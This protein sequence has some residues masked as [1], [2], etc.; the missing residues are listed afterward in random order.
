MWCNV[1]VMIVIKDTTPGLVWLKAAKEVV[2]NGGS[3]MD[4]ETKLKELLNVFLTVEKPTKSDKILEQFADKEM[5]SWM[6]N[7]FL[8]KEPVANWGYSYG[9]RFFDF[10]GINQVEAVIAKLK[11]NHDSKSATI[12]LMSPKGDTQHMPC[13]VA[14]DFKLRGGKLYTTAFFRSQ[15]AGKKLYA[16][17]ISIGEIAQNIAEEV[18]T[19]LGDLNILVASLHVYE[20]DIDRVEKAIKHL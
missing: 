11:K 12:T 17:I 1:F 7:N 8:K 10:E 2:K 15:D 16:D 9:Q 4:G 3:V 19:K 18:G 14:I 5:I 6:K 13:I 20:S